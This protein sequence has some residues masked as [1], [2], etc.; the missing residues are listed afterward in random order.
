MFRSGA[1]GLPLLACLLAS[2]CGGGTPSTP[3]TP[4]PV[5]TPEPSE[6]PNVVVVVSDDLGWGDLGSYGSPANQ[7]PNLDRLAEAGVRMTQYVTTAPLCTP[8][9][10]SLL[11]GLY[12]VQTRVTANLGP[13][14]TRTG[15]T[16]ET[17]S[18][19]LLLRGRGY[20][21]AAVGK[22]GVG[23][24]PQN[25]PLQNGFDS[26]FGVLYESDDRIFDGNGLAPVGVPFDELEAEYTRR[27][28][29]FIRQNA[30]I[31]PFFLYYASHI[32]HKPLR[33]N[34]AFVGRTTAGAYADALLE[35][36]SRVGEIRDALEEAGV[37]R[38]TIVLFT[39]DNG[40]PSYGRPDDGSPGPFGGIGKGSPYEGGIRV[41]AIVSWPAAIPGRQVQDGLVS[42]LDIVPTLGAAGGAVL[43]SRFVYFGGD[44]MPLLR[45][46]AK[47][48]GGPGVNGG[49]ELI[50]FVGANKGAFRS[51]RYKIV[52]PGWW[53]N[54][55]ELYD[56]V[57]DPYETK[58]I[59]RSQ[60]SLFDTVAVRCD[61]V[62]SDA[63]ANAIRE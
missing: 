46:Q 8:S 43:P 5:P 7:T 47:T 52:W 63:L 16:S 38:N 40:P 21:T 12:P 11:T 24:Q 55:A 13:R 48:V 30:K 10:A 14:D 32:P 50:S 49:R 62:L 27:A 56:L 44:V 45:G 4:T 53:A 39:S 35:L 15:L 36:D 58:N 19:A 59:R 57:D 42:A 51:G 25:M 31:R 6:S 23:D 54:D 2:G 34:P 18:L 28:R 9:R 17:P 20:A 1:L 29:A 22:W 41:P 33:T 37:D 3:G 61:V 60:P 26:Y